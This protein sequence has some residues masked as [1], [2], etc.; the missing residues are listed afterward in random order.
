MKKNMLK[1]IWIPTEILLI[2]EISD[3]EKILLSII[4]GLSAEL[5]YCFCSNRY[6]SKLLG[7]TINRVS[8]IVSSLKDKGFIEVT[9][10]Y[11]EEKNYIRSRELKLTDKLLNGIVKSN[12]TY[13]LKQQYPIVKSDYDIIKKYK[14]I[15][16]NSNKGNFE[17]REYTKEEIEKLYC[18]I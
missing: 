2:K 13:G 9:L 10:N 1:G 17:Q 16:N 3:K 8:K 5:G 15:Y 6:L 7:I 14:I 11:D 4:L 12:N 18:N